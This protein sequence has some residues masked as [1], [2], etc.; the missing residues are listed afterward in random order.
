V[1]SCSIEGSSVVSAVIDDKCIVAVVVETGLV[2]VVSNLVD[3][4][5][6]VCISVDV[7]ACVGNSVLIL[8]LSVIAS[9]VVV[10]VNSAVVSV[11]SVVE[12]VNS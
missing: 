11:A 10:L 2:D 5:R 12:V 9:S 4:S 1:L 3:R 6:D 8:E 7:S